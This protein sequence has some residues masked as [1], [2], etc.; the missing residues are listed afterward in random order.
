MKR[1]LTYILSL[2]LL[3]AAVQ[4]S[5][6]Q[7]EGAKII[8]QFKYPDLKWS[9][10]EV[11]K[12]VQRTVLDNGMIVYLMEDHRLPLLDVTALIRCGEAY[13]PD[14]DMAIPEITGDVM[15]TGGTTH[16]AP[17]SLNALLESIGGSLESS[18]SYDNGRARLSV[19]SKDTDLG[20]QLLA[21]L[22]RNPAFPQDKIDLK[23]DQM[24][25]DLK[26]RNDDPRRILRREFSHLVYGD[27]PEGRVLEWAEVKPVTRQDL[28]AYHDAYFVP[29]NIMIGITGDFNS[30]QTL[31]LIKKYFGDWQKKNVSLPPIPTV[32]ETPK[33]GVFLVRKD[34]NQA[35]IRFGHLGIDRDNPDRYAV[36][37]MNFIL[38]GGSFTSRMTSKVRSDEGL[39]YSVG[40]RFNIN[41][42]DEGTFYAYCYTKSRTA[43]K[44]MRLM[45]DEVE[46]IRQGEVSDAELAS[47]KDSYINRFVFD[48]TSPRQI[49]SRLMSLEFDH[50]PPDLLQNY[51]D[52]IRKVTREDVLR[53]AKKYLRPKDITF[54]VVGNPDNFDK[55]LDDFGPITNIPLSDPD[56]N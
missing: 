30:D 35:N 56:I 5:A 4:V 26:R 1:Y 48:F 18:I 25:S 41:Q 53:V 27:H 6:Q 16:I 29:N 44:A 12:D 47:A 39:A 31:S 21:D 54:V 45:L 36:S 3:V 15:R 34:I 7:S 22:L 17:D 50:R 8:A 2:L 10:P 40:S 28:I 46:R 11:G 20:M 19:M 51:I 52:N 13:V 49:V 14:K 43:H 37:V 23:K 24:K 33:P 42:P 32:N 38:G 9:V 55:P